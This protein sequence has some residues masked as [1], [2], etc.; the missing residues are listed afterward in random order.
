[1]NDFKNVTAQMIICELDK[2]ENSDLQLIYAAVKMLQVKADLSN[3]A[4]K[5]E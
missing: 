1:M 2:I 4:Q 5:T 3:V